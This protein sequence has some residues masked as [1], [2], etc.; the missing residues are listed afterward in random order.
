ML[1][2]AHNVLTTLYLSHCPLRGVLDIRGRKKASGPDGWSSLSLLFR[3]VSMRIERASNCSF[4]YV[5]HRAC[6][7]DESVNVSYP[8][9]DLHKLCFLVVAQPTFLSSK[10]S[11]TIRVQI[12]FGSPVM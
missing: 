8:C 10:L 5:P 6:Y 7:T 4:T 12:T 1:P 11:P 2:F 3:I 9:F